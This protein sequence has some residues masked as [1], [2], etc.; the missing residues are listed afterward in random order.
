MMTKIG[1]KGQQREKNVVNQHENAGIDQ[2][3]EITY[4]SL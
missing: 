1:L 2:T 4:L 3:N